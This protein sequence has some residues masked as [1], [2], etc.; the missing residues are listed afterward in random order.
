M[1]CIRVKIFLIWANLKVQENLQDTWSFLLFLFGAPLRSPTKFQ[2]LDPD[3]WKFKFQTVR[4]RGREC[5]IRGDFLLE[6]RKE[7]LQDT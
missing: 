3:P 5:V 1:G 6:E 7:N 2:F 4:M